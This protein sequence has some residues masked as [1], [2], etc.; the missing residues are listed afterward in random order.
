MFSSQIL[1]VA[2]GVTF[3]FILVSVIC[4]AVREVIETFLKTR[5]A[6][7]EQGIRELLHDD[8][9]GLTEA[10]YNHPLIYS[11]FSGVPAA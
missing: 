8:D 10:L 7:L 11:L 1:E 3:V 2:I 5:S 6:Y 4:T 9:D